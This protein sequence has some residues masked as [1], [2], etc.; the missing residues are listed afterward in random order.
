MFIISIKKKIII[1][2]FLHTGPARA[3]QEQ[4]TIPSLPFGKFQLIV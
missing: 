2:I 1:I 4:S 3:P